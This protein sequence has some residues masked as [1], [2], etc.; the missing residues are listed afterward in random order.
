MPPGAAFSTLLKD[1]RLAAGLTQELLA[2]RAEVSA[3]PPGA[4]ARRQ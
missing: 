1:S 2:E 3:R 4:G